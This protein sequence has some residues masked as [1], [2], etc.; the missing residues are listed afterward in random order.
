MSKLLKTPFFGKLLMFITTIIWGSAFFILKDTIDSFPTFYVLAIRFSIAV[1]VLCLFSLKKLIKM[2]KEVFLHGAVLGLIFYMAYLFQTTGL[3]L[4]TPSKNAFLTACYVI[5]VPFLVWMFYKKRPSINNILASV[6]CLVGIGL[7]SLN[8][9]LNINLG[10]MLT[11]IAGLFFALQIIFISRYANKGD[12]IIQLLIAELF[13]ACVLL[14]ITTL[15]TEIP[16]Y[17]KGGVIPLKSLISIIYLSVFATCFAQFA[18]MKGQE[19]TNETTASLI[20]SLEAVFGTIFSI[21]FY[22]ERLTT[23]LIVGFVI[24]FIGLIINELKF[25]RKRLQ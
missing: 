4:T 2:K 13:V 12:D 16:D 5:F 11:L 1:L 8:A 19:L 20:L 15:S 3:K 18:Q 9:G 7:V 17:P 22:G 24:I 6:L 14:W 23:Q 25:N 10:D 21:I